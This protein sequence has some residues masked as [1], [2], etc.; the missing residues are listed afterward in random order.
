MSNSHK[1]HLHDA[2]LHVPQRLGDLARDLVGTSGMLNN[3][4]ALTKEGADQRQRKRDTKPHHHQCKESTKGD[5]IGG[6][7]GPDKHVQQEHQGHQESRNQSRRNNGILGP[8]S[9]LE[10]LVQASRVVSRKRSKK[11]ERCMRLET[12]EQNSSTIVVSAVIS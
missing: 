6:V 10:H 11:T 3:S 2:G 7:L 4:L 8:R 1:E 9:A 12:T 5:G